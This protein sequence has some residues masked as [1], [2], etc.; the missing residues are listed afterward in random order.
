MQKI[1]ATIIL[2]PTTDDGVFSQ[3]FSLTSNVQE[4]Q[5]KVPGLTGTNKAYIQQYFETIDDYLD[6]SINGSAWYFDINNN[7]VFFGGP[8]KYRIRKTGTDNVGV[9]VDSFLPYEVYE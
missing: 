3:S 1:G 7:V 2:A 9:S 5:I 4:I 6:V 8:G